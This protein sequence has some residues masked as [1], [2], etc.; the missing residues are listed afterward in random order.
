[1]W[2]LKNKHLNLNLQLNKGELFQLIKQ[3]YDLFMWAS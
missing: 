2:G 3:A 1:M